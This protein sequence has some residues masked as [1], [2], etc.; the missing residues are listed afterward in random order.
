MNKVYLFNKCLLSSYYYVLGSVDIDRR[1]G[2][3]PKSIQNLAKIQNLAETPHK[4]IP[5]DGPFS[6]LPEGFAGPG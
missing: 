1:H 5:T 6:G 3:C 4:H 2:L